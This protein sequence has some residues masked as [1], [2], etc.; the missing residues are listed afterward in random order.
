M[1]TSGL[2]VEA[3]NGT[4]YITEAAHGFPA[5]PTGVCHPTGDVL[6]IEKIKQKLAGSD[7]VF[8]RRSMSNTLSINN[9][10]V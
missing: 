3:P 8:A 1:S 10:G 2:A 7:I 9:P 5:P 6:R 4:E